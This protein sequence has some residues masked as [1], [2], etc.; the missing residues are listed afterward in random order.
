MKKFLTVL[1]AVL[2]M[3]CGTF[4]FTGCEDSNTVVVYTNAFFPPFEYY[5]GDQIAG[6]D[7]EI[8][9]KVGEKLGKT[10]KI[11][12]TEFDYIIDYVSSGKGKIG[13]AGITITDARKERV[14]FSVP[15][16]TSVQYIIVKEDVEVELADG[17]ASWTNLEGKRIGVQTNT[18]GDLFIDYE[19]GD[20]P[21]DEYTGLLYEKNSELVQLSDAL[22]AVEK[23]KAGQ[24]D[25]VVIDKLPAEH[26]VGHQT[27]IKCY[28]LL[29]AE[30]E[31]AIC[32]TKG[33]DEIL[34][35]INEVLNEMMADVDEN[36]E[37]AIQRDQDAHGAD[38]LIRRHI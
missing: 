8:M 17:I 26:I 1:S 24:V 10:M 25:V 31:Y 3:L 33:E 4:A 20:H 34:N 7:V 19:L 13:A 18:T 6:V 16:Y 22:V 14:N 23:L 30:E 29:N 32:V 27:G 5:Q 35:A 15:Y 11:V 2:L 21:E 28:P 36:G 9:D 12:N 37:N 38:R